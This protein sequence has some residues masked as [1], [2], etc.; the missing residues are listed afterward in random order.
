MGRAAT[1]RLTHGLQAAALQVGVG[2]GGVLLRHGAEALDGV[3]QVLLVQVLERSRLFRLGS[4]SQRP[5]PSG[6]SNPLRSTGVWLE[7]SLP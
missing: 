1:P 3:H 5:P 6:S 2:E 4:L 7:P